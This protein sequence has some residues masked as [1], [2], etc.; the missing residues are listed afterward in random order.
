MA[1]D[2]DSLFDLL[3]FDDIAGGKHA[4]ETLDLEVLVYLDATAAGE[5]V[6]PCSVEELGV[7]AAS[8]A[9]DLVLFKLKIG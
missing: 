8:A 6:F 4:L 9:W 3:P 2:F 1:G 7:W 5:D